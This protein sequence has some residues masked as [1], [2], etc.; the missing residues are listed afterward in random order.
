MRSKLLLAV[1]LFILTGQ[2]LYAA[3]PTITSFTPAQGYVGTLV[4]ITGTNMGNPTAFSIGGVAAIVVSNTGTQLVGMVMPGAATGTI[5]VTTTGGTATGTGTFTLL[6][7]PE[8]YPQSQQGAPLIGTNG[9]GQPYQGN[10]VAIS[11]DGNT[12]IV[13]GYNDN[14]NQ[15]AGWFYT[16]TNGVWTQQGAKVIPSDPSGGFGS[17]FGSSVA[18]SADGNTAVFGGPDDHTG[19]GATWVFTRTAGVWTQQGLKLVGTGAIANNG[20]TE[21]N[22]QQGQAVALSADGNTIISGGWFD[23]GGIGAAWVFTR[24][25]GV[26]TQLGSKLLGTNGIGNSYQ[27]RA[28]ALSADGKTALIGGPNDNSGQGAT[29]VFTLSGGAWTQQTEII[30]TGNVGAAGQGSAV[31]LSADGNTAIIGGPGDS[32]PLG[33]AWVF[34]RSGTAW[35]Q[36]TKLVGTGGFNYSYGSTEGASVTVSADGN[37]AVIGGTTD[38]DN[39]GAIWVFTRSGTAWTQEGNK[40]FGT[41]TGTTN[42]A[43]QGTSVAITP[44]GSTVIEGGPGNNTNYGVAYVFTPI[45]PTA[46][47]ES[48]TNITATTVTLYGL[49][50]SNGV[51]CTADFQYGTAPDLTGA[52][53]T[54][55][56]N[57][58]SNPVT[59]DFDA[60][61]SA[62]TGLTAATKYYWRASAYN[63]NGT[64]NGVI[65]SF[66]T[67][68][69]PPP[70]P[71]VITFTSPGY[72]IYGSIT[73]PIISSTDTIQPFNYR[74]VNPAVVAITSNGKFQAVGVG[75]TSIVA[76]QYA[77]GTTTIEAAASGNITVLQ[78]PLTVTANNVTVPFN[79]PIPPLTVTY[80]GFVN[81]DTTSN[82]TTPATVYTEAVQGS[83]AGTYNIL[84]NDNAVD[85]NYNIT[86]VDGLLTI[87]PILPVPSAETTTATNINPTTVTLN[88]TAS[89]QGAAATITFEYTTDDSD[90]FEDYTTVTTTT[91]PNPVPANSSDTTFTAA[92]TGLL[93]GTT[94][95]FR[96][97]ST[98]G[99]FVTNGNVLSFVTPAALNPET[100]TFAQPV[101]EVYGSADVVP[102][103]TST[104]T[105]VPITYT[106]SN[107]AVATIVNS[108]IHIIGVGTTQITASQAGDA[109]HDPATPVMQNFTVTAAGLTIMPN[110]ATK[111]YGTINPAF[112]ANYTGFVNGDNSSVLTTLPTI[113][114]TAGTGSGVG[115]YQLT[116]SGAVAANYTITYLADTLSITPAPLVI[117]PNN[118][119]RAYGA[120]NPSFTASYDGLVNGDNQASL[121]TLPAITTSAT[122]TSS[123]GTYPII[124]SGAVDANYTITYKPGTLTIGTIP[125]TI[126]ANNQTTVYGTAIPALTVSYTGFVN[127]DSQS[128]LTTQPVVTTTAT[129]ASGVGSYTITP[130]GAAAKNYTITYVNG[131]LTITPATLTITADD[132]TKIAGSENPTLTV[133][134]SGFVNEDSQNNLT[135]LPTVITTATTTSPVGTYPITASGAVDVNYNITYVAGTL[136][137]G[138]PLSINPFP[139]TTYGD[140]DFNTVTTGS[141]ITY[142]SGNTSV[143]T[144]SSTGTIHI[145]GA[146]SVTITVSSGGQSINQVLVVNPAPL[147]IAA[148]DQSR[149]YGADNPAFTV[150]YTGFVYSDSQ[151]SLST[152][153]KVVTTATTTSDVGTYPI[154]AS[155]AADANYTITYTAGTLTVTQAGQTITFAPIPDQTLPATYDLGAVTAA[156]G[157]PVTF[158]LSDPTLASISGTTLTLLKAGTET[159]TASQAGNSNYKAAA[160]VSQTFNINNADDGGVIVSMVVSPN[161]DGINDFL[162]IFNIE[163][164]PDNKFILYNRNGVKVFEMLNYDNATHVFIGRSNITGALQQQGT[165]LYQLEYKVNGVFKRKTGFTELRYSN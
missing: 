63:L 55:T 62:V 12:A 101:N 116:A 52:T 21:G 134:Y 45:L 5:K 112:T 64:V 46:T 135:T 163:N 130:D 140:P 84:N 108:Q 158:T 30:A 19:T 44:D 164:Y 159:I 28:V 120:A 38:D 60:I 79:Q 157:L 1:I 13:G 128:N 56:F 125:L 106:S 103:A 71:P 39:T 111:V 92:I 142:S 126:T 133:T 83:Q 150:T 152:E 31:A 4:T 41:G 145:T 57:Q 113:T 87:T 42:N 68:A 161:G 34:T 65:D 67:A 94:Y 96:I 114:T 127:G 102:G 136:T 85:P 53:T 35:S 61:T 104:N 89:G 3:T 27:G 7:N 118:A 109:T 121:T 138:A 88:G 131:T 82:L 153:P 162:H 70:P 91:G 107:T 160:D 36:Q 74:S 137:V 122:D 93:P 66:T 14:S 33:A 20:N 81:G 154:T 50:S 86:Y 97:V 155:G 147:T 139:T 18:I 54:T 43:N 110:Y 11:A 72:V 124:A 26:W 6:V 132:Q 58:G 23:N 59:T 17:Y 49:F 69:A 75:S 119:S 144:I 29:W 115:I 16:R 99:E 47:T 24:S 37:T 2:A 143:A 105:A 141:N 80:K 156:S 98:N 15:G 90:G 100:I 95:Y 51:S 129:A 148:N 32:A 165:Y 73:T 78:A 48:A 9:L 149:A 22:A 117:T 10:S 25:G 40:L 76:Y 8:G 123:V 151:S 77:P 146:G